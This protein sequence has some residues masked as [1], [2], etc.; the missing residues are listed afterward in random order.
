[1][2]R[3]MDSNTTFYPYVVHIEFA[4]FMYLIKENEAQHIDI[5]RDRQDTQIELPQCFSLGQT[6]IKHKRDRNVS[7]ILLQVERV[8]QRGK[9]SNSRIVIPCKAVVSLE[10]LCVSSFSF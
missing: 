2:V 1:M 4:L 9:M 7:L 3:K 10:W 8:L 5:G 6:V